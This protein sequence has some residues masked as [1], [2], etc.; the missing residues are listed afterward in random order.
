MP[1]P[2]AWIIYQEYIHGLSVEALAKKHKC[3]TKRI[4]GCIR[5]SK[6]QP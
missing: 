1:K 3:S 6:I 5:R 4:Y 2:I